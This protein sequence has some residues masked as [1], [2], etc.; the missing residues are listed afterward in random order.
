MK[1][2]WQK[3]DGWIIIVT[4]VIK[5]TQGVSE[6]QQIDNSPVRDSPFLFISSVLSTCYHNS[7]VTTVH[8]TRK[9][10]GQ[11]NKICLCVMFTDYPKNMVR[12]SD[13][14]LQIGWKNCIYVSLC[15]CVFTPGCSWSRSLCSLWR[16][17]LLCSSG[18]WVW[19]GLQLWP[20]TRCWHPTLAPETPGS[21]TKT[22]WPNQ[23]PSNQSVSSIKTL[24]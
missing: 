1:W 8:A 23:Q 21:N 10:I 15:V 11:I 17:V 18:F 24:V 2:S 7:F 4:R 19:C 14:W 3:E 9:L 13:K 6:E 22:Q 5:R 20:Q 12:R 16:S